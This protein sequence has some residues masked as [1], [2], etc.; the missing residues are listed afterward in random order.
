MASKQVTLLV[1]NIFTDFNVIASDSDSA[2]DFPF[3]GFRAVIISL[4]TI[5]D[6]IFQKYEA[7]DVLFVCCTSL[8]FDPSGSGR[9]CSSE[10]EATTPVL[11]CPVPAAA[12]G[13]GFGG[14]GADGPPRGQR[15]LPGERGFWNEGIRW[16]EN[17]A[18]VLDQ[19]GGLLRKARSQRPDGPQSLTK[20]RLFLPKG[21]SVEFAAENSCPEPKPAGEAACHKATAYIQRCSLCVEELA[22]RRS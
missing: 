14:R 4:A 9:L 2:L 7:P 13:R 18:M 5:K 10:E 8:H 1:R 17:P 21:D 19:Q 12:G 20:R 11:P 6:D 3:L 22:F 16:E 15:A